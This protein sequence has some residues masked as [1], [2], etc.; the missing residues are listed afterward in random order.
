LNPN[1]K[2]LL[3]TGGWN[4][5]SKVYSDM[6]YDVTLRKKFARTSVDFLRKYGFDGLDLDWEYPALRGGRSE[7][8][9]NFIELIKVQFLLISSSTFTKSPCMVSIVLD[10]GFTI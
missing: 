6:V 10:N 5:G 4:A 2:T 3:A 8:K 7:D 1:L 9:V